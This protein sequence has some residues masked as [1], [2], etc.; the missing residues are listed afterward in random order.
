MR[1]SVAWRYVGVA[2][3]GGGAV[4][5][6][7]S[8][9]ASGAGDGAEDAATV[10]PLDGAIATADS[11]D[12]ADANGSKDAGCI[13]VIVDDPLT[14]ISVL[15]WQTVSSQSDFPQAKDPGTGTLMAAINATNQPSQH[16]GLWLRNPVPTTAFDVSFDYLLACKAG[17]YCADGVAAAWL[18]TLDAGALEKGN[19]GKELGIPRLSG[20]AAAIKLDVKLSDP[21]PGEDTFPTLIVHAMDAGIGALKFETP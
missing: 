3:L 15:T 11:A 8:V 7:I 2:A 17:E 13:P 4:A 19:P 12:G 21:N 20:G 5:C 16:A 10:D 6:G 1:R 18:D 14:S 9:V